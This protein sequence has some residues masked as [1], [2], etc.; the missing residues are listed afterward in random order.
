MDEYQR[1]LKAKFIGA[2]GNGDGSL[3]KEEFAV[4]VHPHRHEHMVEHLVQDQLRNY[5]R[6]QDGQISRS[7]Y[8]SELV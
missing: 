6:D 1:S 5:D 8:L 4:F 7:E 3:N 2:D